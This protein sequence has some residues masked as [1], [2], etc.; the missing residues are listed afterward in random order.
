MKKIHVFFLG[1]Y[2]D[3]DL[4]TTFY[5]EWDFKVGEKIFIKENDQKIT[6][7]I[8]QITHDV[9]ISGDGN[10]EHIVR[11]ICDRTKNYF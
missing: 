9:L 2:K 5:S 6:T 8:R 1:D 3:K 4:V 10:T 11:L 7:Q